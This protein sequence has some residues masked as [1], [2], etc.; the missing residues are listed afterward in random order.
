MSLPWVVV[1]VCVNTRELRGSGDWDVGCVGGI[2]D[3]IGDVVGLQ[4]VMGE[5]GMC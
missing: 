3:V 4:D 5:F 1:K 2:W